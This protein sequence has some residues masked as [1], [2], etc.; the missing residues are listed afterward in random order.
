MCLKA[1]GSKAREN[2]KSYTM[3]VDEM[4]SKIIIL[5]MKKSFIP[6]SENINL[7]SKIAQKYHCILKCLP[8]L[9]LLQ[10]YVKSILYSLKWVFNGLNCSK[11]HYYALGPFS[12]HITAM[13]C[14]P[15]VY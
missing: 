8:V 1:K 9:L 4:L 14:L 6:F 13:Y 5:M 15:A 2:L 11:Y 10:P 3:E 7:K 12:H